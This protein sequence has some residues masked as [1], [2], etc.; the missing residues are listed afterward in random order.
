MRLIVLNRSYGGFSISQECAPF[1]AE[2][3]HQGALEMLIQHDW[4]QTDSGCLPEYKAWD[5]D[6]KCDRHDPILIDA[7][8]TLG[9]KAGED[10]QRLEIV[11]VKSD[12]YVIIDYDGMEYFLTPEKMSWVAFNKE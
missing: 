9:E 1:M 2:A 8:R 12:R 5:A 7:V 10:G 6:I 3:G 4:K 11:E